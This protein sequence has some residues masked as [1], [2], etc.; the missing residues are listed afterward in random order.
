MT[1]S[2]IFTSLS[3]TQRIL[4]VDA[5]ASGQAACGCGDHADDAPAIAIW[6]RD[7]AHAP[8]DIDALLAKGLAIRNPDGGGAV[9]HL[10]VRVARH[11][12]IGAGG[13]V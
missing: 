8:G 11:D 3:A 12:S 7:L 4:L 6:W 1:E 5:T 13:G 9:T 2:E 10:G